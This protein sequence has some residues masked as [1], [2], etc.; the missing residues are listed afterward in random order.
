MRMIFND[1][2]GFVL[3]NYLLFLIGF[4]TVSLSVGGAETGN[5]LFNAGFE[6]V[7]Y[8]YDWK[9]S[10]CGVKQ[11]S[12]SGQVCSGKLAASF[13]LSKGKESAFIENKCPRIRV[14]PGETFE[15][16]VMAKGQGSLSLGCAML[17]GTPMRLKGLGSVSSKPVKLDEKWRKIV[18][19]HTFTRRDVL[20]FSYRIQ[21]QGQGAEVQ[22]DDA[23]LVQVLKRQ[24]DFKAPSGNYMVYP[25]QRI[26]I[27]VAVSYKDDKSRADLA[28]VPVNFP[29]SCVSL[30]KDSG[31]LTVNV[32]VQSNGKTLRLD[33][34]DRTSGIGRQ[35]YLD[36]VSRTQYLAVEQVM[37]RQVRPA[38]NLNV[39]VL[40]DSLSDLYRGQNY[41]DLLAFWTGTQFGS[42][43]RW[44]N[45]GVRGDYISR[46]FRRLKGDQVWGKRR[47]NDI[48]ANQPDVAFIFCGHNDSRLTA[49][50]KFIS[51]KVPVETFKKDLLATVGLLRRKNPVIKIVL[52]TPAASNF[53]KSQAIWRQ[54]GKRIDL[55]GQPA[56]MKKFRDAVIEAAREQKCILIDLYKYTE[57]YPAN[58]ELFQPDGVHLSALGNYFVTLKIME[59][60]T[61]KDF[62]K[63]H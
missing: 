56:I 40:G 20:E 49:S 39:L 24:A 21:L 28:V 23:T 22:L 14:V 55:F 9:T 44:F 46:I 18:F 60:L 2:K 19:T 1:I 48:F 5:L 6:D 11:V 58:A 41:V 13:K 50:S 59:N 32:P 4:L 33:L 35:V 29:V 17:G 25:G 63:I 47:Y 31:E 30:N 36:A 57:N 7:G 51:P 42:D 16:S 15:L 62:W 45:Y 61:E 52:L 37:K 34:F 54:K 10:G 26:E 27:K 8:V 53:A 12:G 43:I 3:K 38:R